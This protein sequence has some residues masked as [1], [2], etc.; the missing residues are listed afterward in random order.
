MNPSLCNLKK[1]NLKDSKDVFTKTKNAI[2]LINEGLEQIRQLTKIDK[3]ITNH[4]SRH[5]FG[6]IAGDKISPKMLQK[7]YRHSDIKTTMGYQGNFI[8]KSTD[9]ALD[10]VVNF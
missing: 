9:D 1:A 10:S 7:L 3:K 5:T 6:N 8:H 2:K 4:I